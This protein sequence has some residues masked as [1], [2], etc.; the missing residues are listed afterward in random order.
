VTRADETQQ[1]WLAYRR[2]G[3]Q[4]IRDRLILTYEPLLKYVASR[5][6]VGLSAP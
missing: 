1:L 4:K 5:L 2:T 6:L 3:D